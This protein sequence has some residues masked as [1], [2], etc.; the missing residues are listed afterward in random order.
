NLVA[1]V[2]DE[3]GT[4]INLAVRRLNM[5]LD[6]KRYREVLA[7]GLVYRSDFQLKKPGAYQ[8]RAVLR[9]DET[10]RTGTASQFIQAPD[11]SKNHLAMSGIVLMTPR[12]SATLAPATAGNPVTTGNPATAGNKDAAQAVAPVAALAPAEHDDKDAEKNPTPTG[13]L[14]TAYVRK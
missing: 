11:L 10:G 1:F 5:D 14:T 3:E 4:P 2:F 6:E 12:T 7:E 13:L 8:F 9:D